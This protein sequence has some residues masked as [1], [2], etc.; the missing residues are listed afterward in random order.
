MVTAMRTILLAALLFS[1][2]SLQAQTL[3]PQSRGESQSNAI[4]N[5]LATQS[6]NRGAAQQNQFEINSLRNQAPPQIVPAPTIGAPNA[7]RR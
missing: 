4:N 6:Q 1:T 5:S 7:P 2:T 3:L